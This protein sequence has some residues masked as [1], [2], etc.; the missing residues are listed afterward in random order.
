MLY[1]GH[2]PVLAK[3]TNRRKP[4]YI[5]VVKL[6]HATFTRPLPGVRYHH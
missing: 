4:A 1:D 5:Q 2:Y 6:H 3:A